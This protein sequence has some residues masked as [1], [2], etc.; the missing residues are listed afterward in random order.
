MGNSNGRETR[1]NYL[2]RMPGTVRDEIRILVGTTR[3]SEHG[4]CI[5]LLEQSLNAIDRFD[6][7]MP[8]PEESHSRFTLRLP[9]ALHANI[10][11]AS[12][13]TGVS[14][15]RIINGCLYAGAAV[16]NSAPDLNSYAESAL[17]SHLPEDIF[18]DLKGEA[19]RAEVSLME[20]AAKR[21]HRGYAT[22][23]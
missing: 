6:Y 3:L 13:R 12:L 9:V 1:I 10:K 2:L 18:L 23:A 7:T 17:A 11:E 20:M 15:N 8:A 5:A 16:E 14:M 4:Q 19:Q 21:I 22:S